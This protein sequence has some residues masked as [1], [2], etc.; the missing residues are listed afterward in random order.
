MYGLLPAVLILALGWLFM[1]AGNLFFRNSR[2]HD[3]PNFRLK[4]YRNIVL[5]VTL[6]SALL[7]LKKDALSVAAKGFTSILPDVF[8]F[9][10]LVLLAIIATNTAM[11]LF[12]KLL[13]GIGI[14]DF[15]REDE[16]EAVF[17]AFML[18]VRAFLYLLLTGLALSILGLNLG[19]I[20]QALNFLIYAII[21]SVVLSLVIGG[22]VFARN[23][24]AG[25]YVRSARQFREGSYLK[26]GNTA[27]KV[28]SVSF[29]GLHLKT[30]EGYR[31]FVP[32]SKLLSENV[33]YKSYNI[34]L[35]SL[36]RIVRHFVSQ[37]P[38]ACGPAS[39]AMVLSIF[40]FEV[41]QKRI[42][43][44]AKTEVGKGTHPRLLIDAV[45]RL[46]RGKV[47]GEWIPVDA[48]SD[49]KEE[50]Q[51]WL[52]DGALLIVDFKK[53]F[54]FPESTKA[55]YSVLVAI[56]GNEC[57][58]L[59]PSGKKGGVYLVNYHR[60]H[61]GMDT[62]SELLEG[63]RGYIVLAP[64]GTRA[65]HRIAK[66]LI[67]ADITLYDKLSSQLKKEMARIA[68]SLVETDFVIPKSVKKILKTHSSE[69][70][71]TRLWSPNV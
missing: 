54:L 60:L 35:K 19:I 69:E 57:V 53:S 4:T 18:A 49:F 17:R 41:T 20:S 37:D 67:Y 7:F 51:S 12:E 34:D 31:L 50:A 70:F 58:I 65:Y 1:R 40:G 26:I 55:H 14:A 30:K 61:R 24:S 62:Y 39:A 27:G 25:L 68:Q 28:D 56:E 38:S 33:F 66:G 52:I 13:A 71:V 48:I 63:K 29:M 46:T 64:D 10:L 16:R 8:A 22:A 21:L 32:H 5:L 3:I 11:L 47:K 6:F 44:L 36:G 15:I 45:E 59:D 43:K 2:R 42:E 23:F 9:V